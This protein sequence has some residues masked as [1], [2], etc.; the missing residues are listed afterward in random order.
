MVIDAH[1]HLWQPWEQYMDRLL[2]H[3]YRLGIDR[4]VITGW[5]PND[6]G[7]DTMGEGRGPPDFCPMVCAVGGLTSRGRPH[8]TW[9]Q[10][11]VTTDQC[12]THE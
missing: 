12:Y 7:N 5:P 10:G 9:P 4:V 11:K 8:K 1:H 2:E 6:V 3:S